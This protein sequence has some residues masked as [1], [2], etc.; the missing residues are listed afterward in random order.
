MIIDFKYAIQNDL[1]KI[2]STYNSTIASGIVTAELKPVSD[3]SKQTWFDSHSNSKRPL[4]IVYVDDEYAGWMSFK[5]FY[6]R[7]AY[8]GTAEI[9][10]YLDKNFRGIGIGKFCLQ[11]A[12]EASPSLKINI[13]LGFIFSHNTTSLNLFYKFGFKNWGHLPEVAQISN[14]TRDLIIVGKKVMVS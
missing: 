1:P 3:E 14:V 10:I 5:D 13:I 2:V 7:P 9:S 11:K 12:I 6:G 8:D 4:W